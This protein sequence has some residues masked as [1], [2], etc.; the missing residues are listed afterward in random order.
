MNSSD[1]S[2]VEN[3]VKELSY[4]DSWD[5]KQILNYI[6]RYP[7][8]LSIFRE[9]DMQKYV[10]DLQQRLGLCE[11]MPHCVPIVSFW[12]RQ[13]VRTAYEEACAFE[14]RFGYLLDGELREDKR[15]FP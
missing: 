1:G 12:S 9:V 11:D 8:N 5:L 13:A 10:Y 14:C 2:V 7:T 4:L 3:F 6:E 15:T